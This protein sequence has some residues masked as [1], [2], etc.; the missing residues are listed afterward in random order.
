MKSLVSLFVI[1]CAP[2]SMAKAHPAPE[3]DTQTI[4]STIAE[5]EPTELGKADWLC[6]HARSFRPDLL[7]GSPG[8]GPRGPA[9]NTDVI[10]YRLEI[11]IL[12]QLDMSNDVTAVLVHGTNT[13]DV[14]VTDAPVSQFVIDLDDTMNVIAVTGDVLSWVHA[15]DQIDITLDQTYNPGASFQVIVEYDGEP[16]SAGFGAFQWWTRNDNLA[17][18]TLSEPYFAPLWWPCKDSLSDKSTMQMI[19]TAPDP[20]VGVSNGILEETMPLGDGRTRYSWHESN[21]M[22]N[23]LASLAIT[24]YERYDQTY[25]YD[26]GNGGTAMMPVP[27]Y[28]YPDHWDFQLDEPLPE[29]KTGCNEMLTMLS[30]FESKLGP[31]PFRSEKYGV[32]ETG[33]DGGLQANMEHQTISSMYRVRNYSD[34]MAHEMGHQWFGDNITCATWND[35]WLNEG[36]TSYTEALY[37]EFKPSG[38]IN[39]YWTRMNARRPGSP[40]NKVYRSNIS[41]VGGIFS[42]ND[43]YNKGAWVCHM[44]RH[45]MGDAAFFQA[46]ADY[47]AAYAESYATTADFIASISTSFGNDMTWFT[48]QWVMS[49]GAPDYTW[50]YASANV[51][52]QNYLYLRVVQSQNLEGFGLITMPIDIRVTTNSGSS[53]HRIWNNNWTEYYVIPI[54]GPPL[55]VE[56]DEAGGVD[57]RN[58]V[59]TS[60]KVFDPA[61]FAR[62]PVIVSTT[63]KPYATL[64]GD[65]SIDLTFSEDIGTLDAA[66]VE[67]NGLTTGVMPPT[68]IIYN[69]AAKTATLTY[70]LLPN[71]S[72]LL[73]VFDDN[74]IANGLMLD[75]EVGD[76]A[77]YDD[78]LLPSGDGQPGG[79]AEFS[80][81]I[82]AGDANCD[83][84]VDL[85]DIA[86]FTAV[87]LGNDTIT[88]HVLR[89]D[90]NNDGNAD[91][92]DISGFL[93]AILSP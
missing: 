58:Y 66:D 70:E 47:R 18:A 41:S 72:F 28:V 88:C 12:P 38:G 25:E 30:V 43:V 54:N 63:F 11:E 76:S 51:G 26:D 92:E 78:T 35:I 1:V 15:T 22:T 73:S 36:L 61:A 13:I 9:G 19:I 68:S 77:W 59:L 79:D 71:D 3:V 56:F 87:L 82:P 44:L 17:V 45:V 39:S 32:A 27:C 67:L 24:N 50:N 16:D 90:V 65:T 4:R 52:G 29:D 37:R 53:V 89:S 8:E 33:G 80:F 42:T 6:G 91:G 93:D 60:T 83:E 5:H 40:N 10:H 31:Y 21:P 74:V 57:D 23:Y 75:G 46:L 20:M 14:S 48:N 84:D 69:P 86:I 2:I 62:P 34:I 85:D 7:P 55:N 81:V 49:F 64:N